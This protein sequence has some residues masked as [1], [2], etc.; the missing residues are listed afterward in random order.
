M[1]VRTTVK[2]AVNCSY[3]YVNV[4]RCASISTEITKKIRTLCNCCVYLCC[5]FSH[6]IATQ[7][8]QCSAYATTVTFCH[9]SFSYAITST[10]IPFRL[11]GFFLILICICLRLHVVRIKRHW[12]HML[13]IC[14]WNDPMTVYIVI[15]CY[16]NVLHIHTHVKCYLHAYARQRHLRSTTLLR[17]RPIIISFKCVYLYNHFGSEHSSSIELILVSTH[18]IPFIFNWVNVYL[19]FVCFFFINTYEKWL[20]FTTSFDQFLLNSIQLSHSIDDQWCSNCCVSLNDATF[21]PGIEFKRIF[22]SHSDIQCEKTVFDW[23]TKS[24]QM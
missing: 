17:L 3:S 15:I 11:L 7:Y 13:T 21:F 1:D 4:N 12:Q 23:I 2:L 24:S 10:W 5:F 9:R 16:Y 6:F 18:Q 19:L 22:A 20:K 8:S 14:R